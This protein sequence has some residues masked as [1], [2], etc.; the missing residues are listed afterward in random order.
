MRTSSRPSL[1]GGRSSDPGPKLKSL[2]PLMNRN[3][4]DEMFHAFSADGINELLTLR[5]GLGA[6]RGLIEISS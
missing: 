3:P 6:P 4:R 1:A 2:L 5:Y